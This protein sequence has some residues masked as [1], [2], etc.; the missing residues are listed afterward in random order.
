MDATGDSLGSL[1]QVIDYVGS[2]ATLPYD[3][4][5]NSDNNQARC[6]QRQFATGLPGLPLTSPGNPGECLSNDALCNV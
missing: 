1:C 3:C 6:L 5:A 4:C 2:T